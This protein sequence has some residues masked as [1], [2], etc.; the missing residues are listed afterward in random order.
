MQN[1]YQI[2]WTRPVT[3]TKVLTKKMK[4]RDETFSI[5]AAYAGQQPCLPKNYWYR[6]FH[7]K[8]NANWVYESVRNETFKANWSTIRKGGYYYTKATYAMSRSAEI[9]HLQITIFW[10]RIRRYLYIS[11]V[12]WEKYKSR[13]LWKNR[14][15]YSQNINHLMIVDSIFYFYYIWVY[16]LYGEELFWSSYRDYVRALFAWKANIHFFIV[17]FSTTSYISVQLLSPIAIPGGAQSKHRSIG[18]LETVV[19]EEE[20]TLDNIK[21]VCVFKFAQP[22][23]RWLSLKATGDRMSKI[24]N[25]RV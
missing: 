8:L 5:V 6:C 20:L 2:G 19:V 17:D 10:S 14:G 24:S 1:I 13:L 12:Q 25:D 15:G 11:W 9:D 3:T 21:K 7:S 18:D 16:I 23:E 4:R 22:V